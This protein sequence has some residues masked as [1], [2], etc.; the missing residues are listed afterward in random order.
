MAVYSKTNHTLIHC[1]QYTPT[2]DIL[3]F[4]GNNE[5]INENDSYN[6]SYY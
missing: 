6:E 5:A 2:G 1:F 3:A 4:D